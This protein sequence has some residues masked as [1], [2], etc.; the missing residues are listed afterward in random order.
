MKLWIN[1]YEWNTLEISYSGDE[2]ELAVREYLTKEIADK[3]KEFGHKDD[4]CTPRKKFRRDFM[5][6]LEERISEALSDGYTN[7]ERD[8]RLWYMI[9]DELLS[10][11]VD[12]S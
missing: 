2:G 8:V 3:L 10:L 1:F 5:E 7:W 12:N 11:C 6:F 9:F 4:D